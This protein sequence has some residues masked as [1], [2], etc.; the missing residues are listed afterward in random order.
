[1]YPAAWPV[2][3]ELELRDGRLLRVGGDFP[4][5]NMENPV[6]TAV[7]EDKFRTLVQPRFGL[8]VCEQAL[9]LVRHLEDVSDLSLAFANLGRAVQAS[10]EV[11]R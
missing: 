6:T 11:V 2:R 1:M 3:L 10:Q 4:R 5:G 8:A 9:D 7:L